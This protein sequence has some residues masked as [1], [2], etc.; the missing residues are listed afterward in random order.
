MRYLW[1]QYFRYLEGRPT[2]AKAALGLAFHYMRIHD[3]SSSHRVEKFIANSRYVASR[4]LQYW[5]REAEVIY[6]PVDIHRFAVTPE[7]DGYYLWVGKVV[8]YKKPDLAVDAFN[9]NR[10]N[11]VVAGGGEQLGAVKRMARKNITFLG[12]VDD[13][14]VTQY[15]QRCRALVFSGI[16]DF[17]IGPVEAMA[18]GKPVI[19]FSRGGVTESVIEDRTRVFFHEPTPDSLNEAI[20]RFESMEGGFDTAEIRLRAEEFREAV[21]MERM[22]NAVTEAWHSKFGA[23]LPMASGLESA[24][25]DREVD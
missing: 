23:S 13:A 22:W 1:E 21:F 2:I 10:R 6:P 16:E 3:C 25:A 12:A 15:L 19:G 14:V 18:C 4:I 8:R 7:N 20:D 17:G 24:A 9:K 5:R 11:L